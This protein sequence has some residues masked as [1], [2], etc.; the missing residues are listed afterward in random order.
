MNN[1]T[2]IILILILVTLTILAILGSIY[3]FSQNKVK[4]QYARISERYRIGTE[5]EITYGIQEFRSL[6]MS[7]PKSRYAPKSLYQI[8]YGYELLY[9]LKK[10]ENKLDIAK[11]EYD[12]VYKKY[13]N[14][15]D[16]QN[17]LFKIA[18]IDYLK[19][20]YDEAQERLDYLLSRYIDTKLKGKIYTE[21]G[22]IYMGLGEYD[23]ALKFFSMKENLNYDETLLGKAE[24]YFRLGEYEKGINI[25]EE[26]IK[27]RR[28]S[29]MKK[30]A[31]NKFLENA[32]KYAKVL[33]QKGDYNRSIMIYQR[34]IDILPD[35]KLVE[36]C[37]YWIGENYYDLRNYSNAISYFQKVLDNTGV[38][39]DDDAVFKIGIC[40]FEQNKFEEALKYFRKLIEYYPDSD[41][42][43]MAK[44]WERQTIREIKYRR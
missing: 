7:Y 37:L 17:A 41:Y 27:F 19:G 20:N 24:C 33:T 26:F 3:Y 4:L 38:G 2:K 1:S 32:Y 28:T 10:D 30:K 6:A 39:K 42:V 34:I 31:I 13:P 8:G 18:H 35:N 9:D 23:R 40:Y 15:I 21:K 44:S 43:S 12:N 11:M 22:Y 14:S 36:N 29:N 5:A 16:A 25:Y